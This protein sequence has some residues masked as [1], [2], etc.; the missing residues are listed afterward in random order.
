MSELTLSVNLLLDVH[1]CVPHTFMCVHMDAHIYV[2]PSMLRL[3]KMTVGC[4][5]GNSNVKYTEVVE[6]K[7]SW[8]YDV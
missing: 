8:I 3:G 5:V 2:Y 6:Y 1:V 4:G 7:I